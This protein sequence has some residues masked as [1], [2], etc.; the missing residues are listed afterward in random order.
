[1]D[2]WHML[3]D[4]V[5]LWNGY[6]NRIWDVSLN[7]HWNMFLN[8]YSNWNSLHQ[9]DG[10]QGVCVSTEPDILGNVSIAVVSMT[11]AYTEIMSHRETMTITMTKTMTMA[12]QMPV[13][14][15]SQI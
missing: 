14:Q 12:V 4:F 7:W 1:M 5:G 9:C 10:L 11:V 3:D 13:T 8:G 6:F 2:N 15:I